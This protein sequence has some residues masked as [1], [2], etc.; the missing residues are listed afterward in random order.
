MISLDFL[1]EVEVFQDL[2][3]DQLAAVQSYCKESEYRR[4]D[5][6]FGATEEPQYLW[7]V[8]DGQIELR[9]DLTGYHGFQ[10]DPISILSR[11][12]TFGWSSLVPPFRYRLSA[13]CGSRRCRVLTFERVALS[14]LLEDDSGIGYP[15][16]SRIVA[17]VGERFHQLREE[18]IKGIGHDIM[19]KW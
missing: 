2:N 13:Y 9:Q 17:I 4:G 19:N 18:I 7:V 11:G 14:R 3:D 16:M 8:F 15:V 6:L 1:E 10:A 12:M 5:R